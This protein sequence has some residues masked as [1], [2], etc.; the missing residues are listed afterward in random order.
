MLYVSLPTREELLN[1][2]DVRSEACVSIY[3]ATSPLPQQ[4]NASR[5]ELGNLIKQAVTS[6]QEDGLDKRRLEDLED[7]IYGVTEE[8]DFWQFHA[9][10]L[11]I[12]ATPDSIRTYRLANSLNSQ[13]EVADRFFIKPLLRALTFPHAAYILALSENEARVV[14]FFSDAA[15]ELVKL[16]DMPKDAMSAIGRSSIHTST[17]S[18]TEGSGSRGPKMRLA[19]YANKVDEALRPLL[20]SK[21]SPLVL[22]ST[23]PLASIFRSVVSTQHLVEETIFTSPDRISMGDLVAMARPVLDRHYDKHI[24]DMCKL[25]EER[26]GQNRTATDLADIAKAATYGM[27]SLLLVDFNSTARGTIDDNGALVYSDAPGSLSLVDELVK[28]AMACGAEVLSMRREEM[29]GQTG[30]AA[31]LRYPL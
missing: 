3:L 22:V 4:Q 15:P 19:Q 13:V 9:N 27:V 29:I 11:A 26:S 16:P 8:D 21:G 30:A 17:G 2:S 18:L 5:I 31:V 6:L 25:F 28:R 20:L 12:L 14:E 1:L 7:M 10:S 24:E 23:E